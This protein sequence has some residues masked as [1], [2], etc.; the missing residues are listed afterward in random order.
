MLQRNVLP[1]QTARTAA[2]SSEMYDKSRMGLLDAVHARNAGAAQIIQREGKVVQGKGKEMHAAQQQAKN[3]QE[4]EQGDADLAQANAYRNKRMSD[5]DI[6]AEGTQDPAERN[7]IYDEAIKDVD[8]YGD[9]FGGQ[10]KGFNQYDPNWDGTQGQAQP[11]IPNFRSD[12]AKQAWRNQWIQQRETLRGK[13][14]LQNFR[15]DKQATGTRYDT[16]DQAAIDTVIDAPTAAQAYGLI[17]DHAR[18]RVD[19]GLFSEADKAQYMARVDRELSNRIVQAE[20]TDMAITVR[21]MTSREV[22]A[23]DEATYKSMVKDFEATLAEH[24]DKLGDEL[25]LRMVGRADDLGNQLS[26]ANRARAAQERILR[27]EEEKMYTD[28][29]VRELGLAQPD[30]ARLLDMVNAEESPVLGHDRRRLRNMVIDQM[31]KDSDP[32]KL[33]ATNPQEYESLWEDVY[34]YDP[35]TDPS[36]KGRFE[37]FGRISGMAT[38]EIRTELAG[39]LRRRVN[40]KVDGRTP[41]ATRKYVAQRSTEISGLLNVAPPEWTGIWNK[42][43]DKRKHLGLS[44]SQRAVAM[45]SVMEDVDKAL[46]EGKSIQD[47]E[48]LINNH[49]V[50]IRAQERRNLGNLYH[51]YMQGNQDTRLENTDIPL[52]FRLVPGMFGREES[53][54]DNTGRINLRPGSRIAIP[55]P[56]GVEP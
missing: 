49:P 44:Y 24:R 39:E 20:F 17:D 27:Q 21:E 41:A 2:P 3:Q 53:E 25:V 31:E 19:A 56:Q 26:T 12:R 28:S 15:M 54:L 52:E 43:W 30:Y 50:Y 14:E 45:A 46:A 5:A 22:T 32:K 42:E 16:A 8:A 35:D 36:G 47:I 10:P 33:P 48:N 6:E 4:Q 1:G 13:T 34:S 51:D 18:A 37:L 40:M 29:I 23:E 38:G 55:L 9:G 11:S 7:R